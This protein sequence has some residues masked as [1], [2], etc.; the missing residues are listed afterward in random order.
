M[1]NGI[2]RNRVNWLTDLFIQSCAR[3]FHAFSFFFIHF[4]SHVWFSLPFKPFENGTSTAVNII[5]ICLTSKNFLNYFELILGYWPAGI[6]QILSVS[7]MF[8]LSFMVSG[9]FCVS[10]EEIYKIVQVFFVDLETLKPPIVLTA[11]FQKTS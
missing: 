3:I 6:I 2:S 7:V 1:V 5:D 8:W 4:A 10:S 9:A 11:L